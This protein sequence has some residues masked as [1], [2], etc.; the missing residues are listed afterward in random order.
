M[1]LKTKTII[2]FLILFISINLALYGFS[3]YIL[4]DTL[5]KLEKADIKQKVI[6]VAREIDFL[7]DDINSSIE[8]TAKHKNILNFI[9][10][11]NTKFLYEHQITKFIDTL[12]LS[13]FLITDTK[14]NIQFSIYKDKNA[15]TINK[16]TTYV[17][18]RRKNDAGLIKLDY[19]TYLVSINKIKHPDTLE[20][21][22]YII[23]GKK[24][25]KNLL[26]KIAENDFKELSIGD[27]KYYKWKK[28]NLNG[29]FIKEIKYSFNISDGKFI[30]TY[31]LFSDLVNSSTNIS[32]H[33]KAI[34]GLYLTVREKIYEYI[35][36]FF[37]TGSLIIGFIYF[38]IDKY[39]INRLISIARQVKE[40]GTQ[41][42]LEKRIVVKDNDEITDVAE[43]INTML[44][45]ILKYQKKLQ[46]EEQ[47][48]KTLANLSPIGIY[49]IKNGRFEY[50]N[51]AM[52]NITG[53]KK[54][55][56]IG[57][58]VT[59]IIVNEDIK[60]VQKALN[61]QT[62]EPVEVRFITKENTSKYV[63]VSFR[64]IQKENENLILGVAIDIT[65]LK[66]AQKKI[67]F[68]AYH[69]PLTK[70]PNR[71]LFFDI[72]KQE[73]KQAKREKRNL[74]VMFIDLDRFKEINDTYGHDYGDKVLEIIS[75]RLKNSL[76]ESDIVARLGGDEFGV[77]LPIISKPEDAAIIA[78][79]ILKKVQKPVFVKGK[80]F[81][82]T[83][84][85]GIAIF[86]NDGSTPEELLKAA[87]AA[88]YKAKSEGKNKYFYFSE[89]LSKNLKK[90]VE[91]ERKLRKAFTNK[92]F[93]IV[94]QPFIDLE[95][96]EIIGVEALIRW[97]SKDFGLIRPSK[98][99]SIAE[100]VGLIVDLENWVLENVCKQI[101]QWEEQGIF[102]QKVAVNISPK[103]FVTSSFVKD[104]EIIKQYNV[105]N[106]EI[107]I[108]ESIF[109]EDYDL[110]IKKIEKLKQLGVS[111]SIDDFGTGYSSLSYLKNFPIDIIKID[112]AFIKDLTTNINDQAIVKAVIAIAQ[113]LKIKTLAEGI[114]NQNQLNKLKELGCNYGQ[115]YYILRP[116]PAEELEK[117]LKQQLIMV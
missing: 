103:H 71:N 101:K 59:S 117:Y 40:I 34:R 16:F 57:L 77:I 102:L 113:A 36:I 114:E 60:K 54:Q 98:F 1:S 65:E 90:K 89:D 108:I 104:I 13:F 33:G 24:V 37:I 9:E 5:E 85:I 14:G 73:I 20:T 51:D 43:S 67:E 69:D 105:T 94:Y 95:T 111:I 116:L 30:D 91:L 83:T 64:K 12:G 8:A 26:F 53:Y 78:E 11:K 35:I 100:E 19:Q 23:S 68:M 107:E 39:I 93:R 22:G 28:L 4:F 74:A 112:K 3:K 99:I 7:L 63:I 48:F 115:G 87:D 88:M 84:S 81:L 86:P 96:G 61:L 29:K 80:E 38:I 97:F 92:E 55:N 109:L 58:K 31:F 52:E 50:V 46:E 42:E 17:L 45:E 110:I 62:I 2:T 32:I 82:L 44:E 21:F 25:T 41:K 27:Y 49:I 70:L 76:R 15:K 75:K 56:L 6:S 72:L 47:L 18:N 106:L 10:T 79:K 66:I